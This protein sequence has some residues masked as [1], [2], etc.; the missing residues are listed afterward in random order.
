MSNLNVI[1]MAPTPPPA[2]GI[3]SWAIRYS[4]LATN[5]G[6]ECNICDESLLNKRNVFG[7]KAKKHLISEIKRC[8]KIWKQ[9][10]QLLKHNKGNTVVHCNIPAAPLSI[11]RELV[12]LR[13]AHKKKAKFIVHFRCTVSQSADSKFALLM[14]KK[15]VK[16]ADGVIVLNQASFDYINDHCKKVS[17]LQIIP[18][19]VDIKRNNDNRHFNERIKTVLYVG[20]VVPDKG[21]DNIVKVARHFTDIQFKLIGNPSSLIVNMIKNS[22]IKNVLLLGE[23]N[24]EVVDNELANADAFIFLSRFKHEGF[25]VALTE[26]MSMGLPCIVTDWAANREQVGKFAHHLVVQEP[27]LINKV[28]GAIKY[29][30][31]VNIRREVSIY[32]RN[33]VID[34]YSPEV[35]MKKYYAFYENVLKLG[36]SNDS[37]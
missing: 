31:D 2:G 8:F 28:V 16:K 30:D 24:R 14:L 32:N 33:R 27:D 35:I 37:K 20:G 12:S 19:F 1:L 22:D 29:L 21:C 9:L 5:Y 26:A 4:N 23:Q 6:I 25:S 7:D 10:K 18:N 3:G 34:N 36:K 11:F 13:I 17:Y 15:I